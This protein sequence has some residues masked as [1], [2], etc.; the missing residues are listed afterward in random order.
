LQALPGAEA[1][2][3]GAG[4]GE[5]GAAGSEPAT[6]KSAL[7]SGAANVASIKA[8]IKYRRIVSS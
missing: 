7:A 3:T 4:I 2:A 6:K 8:Y 1:G 5:A